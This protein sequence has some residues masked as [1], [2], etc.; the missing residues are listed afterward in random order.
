MTKTLLLLLLVTTSFN[1]AQWIKLTDVDLGATARIASFNGAIFAYGDEVFRSTDKGASWSNITSNFPEDVYCIYNHN[2]NLLA[3][4]GI[5]AIYAS[6]DLGDTWQA[7]GSVVLSGNNGAILNFETD[8]DILYA[9][10]NRESV[11]KSSDNG[12]TWTELLIVVDGAVNILPIDFAVSGNL[13]VVAASTLGAIISTDAGLTWNTN[14][15]ES[16]IGQ[17][18]KHNGDIYGGTYGFYKLNS[19]GVWEVWKNG[20]PETSGISYSVKGMISSGGKIFA[21]VSSLFNG[22]VYNSDNSGQNWVET[23]S[24]LPAYI[25]TGNVDFLTVS[26]GEL[27]AYMYGLTIFAPGFTGIYKTSVD[28][29]TGVSLENNLPVKF[30]LDQNYPNPF[31]PS[32]MI[33]FSLPTNNFITVSIYNL[34]GELIKIPFKGDLSAGYH[35]INFNATGLPSGTYFYSVTGDGFTESKKMI[36]LK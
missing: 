8:G 28:I 5:N 32:T 33:G 9:L 26:E 29:S 6:E 11:F 7:R 30:A 10:S 36:L 21:A 23:A 34:T 25:T 14:N 18:V 27:Y 31:N 13:I 35:T 17:V 20:I 19:S 16:L 4:S 2:G 15:P 3:I 1:F 12:K 24:G 22:Y